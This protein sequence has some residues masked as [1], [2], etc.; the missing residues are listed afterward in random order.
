LRQ[1]EAADADHANQEAEAADRQHT[2]PDLRFP[3]RV[4]SA[5]RADRLDSGS[6][7]P[8]PPHREQATLNKPSLNVLER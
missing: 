8:T 2:P 4:S 5:D 6:R 3:R 1:L 7:D